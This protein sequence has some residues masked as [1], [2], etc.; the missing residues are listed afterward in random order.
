MAGIS[1]CGSEP[2]RAPSLMRPID[3]G[4]AVSIIAR[5]LR[6]AKLNPERNRVIHVGAN[7]IEVR[8][9]VAPKDA[10]WGIAYVTNQDGQGLVDVLPKRRDPDTFLVLRG[11]GDGEDD[12][13]A[14]LLFAGDYMQDDLAGD[15]HTSTT[16]AAEAK[17]VEAVKHIIRRAND[18]RWP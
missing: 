6:T 13:R 14:V 1:G 7:L 12:A 3:E 10:K 2:P 4:H 17:L 16:I 11:A 9:D 5:E 18:E 8:L 15:A